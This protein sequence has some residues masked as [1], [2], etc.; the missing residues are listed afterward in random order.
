MGDKHFW[1]GM[2]LTIVHRFKSNS[3][4][5]TYL[6][7]LNV[8]P[9]NDT[10]D[11]YDFIRTFSNI[12]HRNGT[13]HSEDIPLLFKPKFVKRF[14]GTDDNYLAS[15]RFLGTFVEFIR[16]GDPN[17]FLTK[18]GVDAW[19]PLQTPSLE[20]IK[21][22]DMGRNVWQMSKLS[23]SD[24]IRVWESLYDENATKAKY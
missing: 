17:H 4:G 24:K 16:N 20:S 6:Y 22:L 11:Y 7:R 5:K 15:Q 8:P 12:P 3:K 2:Y 9:S 21:C 1:H 13:C 14:K 23:N 19:Y 10:Q 18:T